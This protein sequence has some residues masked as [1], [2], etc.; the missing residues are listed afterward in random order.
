MSTPRSPGI[1][2]LAVALATAGGVLI[3]TGIRGVGVLPGLK[4]IL[5]GNPG[6]VTSGPGAGILRP[7]SFRID[8]QGGAAGGGGVSPGGSGP[9]IT[10]GATVLGGQIAN[11]ATRY[12][13]VPYRI[14]GADPSG[15]DCSGLVTWVLHHDLGL[16]LPSNTHTVTQQFITWNAGSVVIPRDQC[17][18][19]DLVC[20]SGHIGIAVSNSQMIDAPHVGTVVDI[21]NIWGAPA[22]VIR[23]VGGSSVRTVST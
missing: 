18:A 3:Y 23:R 9:I 21:H 8:D 19:G 10:T 22:P 17:A 6:S 11:A 13:G 1:P 7:A 14:N 20:W 12:R 5:K 4:E 15:F 16:N 2:G